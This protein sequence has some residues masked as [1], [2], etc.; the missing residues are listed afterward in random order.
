MSA[1]TQETGGRPDFTLSPVTLASIDPTHN[2]LIGR[3]L[4]NLDPKALQ[5]QGIKPIIHGVIVAS[6]AKDRFHDQA[7]NQGITSPA[8]R[9][10]EI[11]STIRKPRQSVKVKPEHFRSFGHAYFFDNLLCATLGPA[12]RELNR[13]ITGEGN[14]IERELLGA[15]NL[16][17]KPAMHS[18]SLAILGLAVT[19]LDEDRKR[20]ICDTIE[21]VAR[22]KEIHLGKIALLNGNDM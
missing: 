13:V 1:I 17:I 16:A 18:Q 9:L 2:Y 5:R 20:N 14:Y 3:R 21:A 15:T 7:K 6:I 19:D 11:V 22:N 4:T 8:D 12:G 10:H